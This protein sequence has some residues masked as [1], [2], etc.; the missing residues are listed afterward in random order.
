MKKL[1]LIVT[2]VGLSCV[3]VAAQS[4][5]TQGELS[6][7]YS[8]LNRDVELV[9]PIFP[10][11]RRGGRVSV[12][13]GIGF[14]VSWNLT[15]YMGIVSDFSYHWKDFTTSLSPTQAKTRD[16]IFLFGPRFYARSKGVT[17]FGHA[18]IGGTRSSNEFVDRLTGG[19]LRSLKISQTNFTLG[20]GGGIDLNPS[21]VV[22]VRAF[23]FD[24]LPTYRNGRWVDN[25][26]ISSGVVFRF[27]DTR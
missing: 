24:Y 7:T 10:D 12:P 22:A 17:G 13:A 6:W 1:F 18:L 26:R 5:A 14:N 20:F 11:I 3:P 2:V 25:Y 9:S 21:E 8:Y 16:F 23:Q 27:G 4:E 19:D 15:S